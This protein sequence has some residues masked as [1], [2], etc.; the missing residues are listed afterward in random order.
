M[1][2]ARPGF[3]LIAVFLY[4]L[5]RMA[6]AADSFVVQDIRL[7]GL[8]R[9]TAG[10]VFNYLPVKVGETL[11]ETQTAEAVRTL[12]KTGFFRD[13]RLERDGDT[14]VVSVVERP[15][16]G[17]IEFPA[18]RISIPRISCPPLNRSGSRRDA[19][20]IGRHS[21]RWSRN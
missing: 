12:F 21:T 5:V 19:S 20:S 6:C 1:I 11:D 13:V 18:T 16:I 7:E 17:R 10:T 2:V 9:I 14:L 15:S 4:A 3:A 8:Q